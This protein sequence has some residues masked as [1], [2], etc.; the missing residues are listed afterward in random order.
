MILVYDV[1]Y[2]DE[3]MSK[4]TEKHLFRPVLIS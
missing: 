4:T 1:D 2:V 3:V